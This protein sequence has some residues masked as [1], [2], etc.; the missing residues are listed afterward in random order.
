M[1]NAYKEITRSTQAF[2]YQRR[3]LD[4]RPGEAKEAKT[5]DPISEAETVT[6]EISEVTPEVVA[7]ELT[8]TDLDK[9]KKSELISY[10]KSVYGED[11]DVTG[12][13]AEIIA[14][15]FS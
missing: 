3:T 4:I 15:F 12:T 7:Q 11:A 13:K 5:V 1:E 8:T 6:V 14:R 9:L 2:M 10:V